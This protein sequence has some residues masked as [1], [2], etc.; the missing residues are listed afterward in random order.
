MDD[1]STSMGGG[2]D[3]ELGISVDDGTVD[4]LGIS[5]GVGSMRPP[6]SV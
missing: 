1:P 4:D 3:D 6:S 5:E 2:A